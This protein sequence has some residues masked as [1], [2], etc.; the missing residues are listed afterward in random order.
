MKRLLPAWLLAAACTGSLDE[1]AT[2]D[3]LRVLA[4]SADPPEVVLTEAALPDVTLAALVADPREPARTITYEWLACGLTDDL[5]CASAGFR[6]R[7]GG[8]DA[9]LA[10]LGATLTI[11]G[12]LL[13][14]A[15]DL[16]TYRG[17]GGVALVAELVLAAGTDE[18]L[19]S[20]KQVTGSLGLPAGTTPNANPT[21]PALRHDDLDWPTDEVL[22]VA[23]DAELSIEPVSPPE[24]AEH[25]GVY[26]FDLRIEELDEHL[27]YD[28]YAS[29]GSWTRSSSGG[30]PSPLATETSLASVWAPPEEPDGPDVTMWIVVRDG[31]GGAAWTERH[32]RVLPP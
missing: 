13:D 17:F 18:E 15:R 29:A 23:P 10:D 26:R 6:E 7:L 20:I 19:H 30:P 24:D 31:R 1:R 3:D 8:G 27:E 25:Y 14:A 16:D 4:I 11:T 32:L 5:R 2:V 9:P 22:D 21:P 12:D 28:F